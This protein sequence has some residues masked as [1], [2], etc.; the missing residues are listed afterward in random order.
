MTDLT[1]RAQTPTPLHARTAEL[2]ATNSWAAQ[3]SF[4]VPNVYSSEREE[5][6]ALASRVVLSDLSARQCWT[7]DGPDAGIYLSFATITDVTTLEPGQTTRTLWCDDQGNARGDGTIV[8]FGKDQFELTTSVRD[9]AWMLDGTL[10]F[11]VKVANATGT[12]A[13]ISVKGP[14][15]SSLL[16]V[17][18]FTGAPSNKGEV[19]Q[20][21]WRPAQIALMRDASGEGYELWTQAD[22]GVVVWDRLWRSG[23]G[24]GVSPMGAAAL[25]TQRIENASPIAGIDWWPAQ[26]SPDLSDCR[27]PVDLGFTPD[28]LRRFNGSDR[29]ARA[30]R[31]MRLVQVCAD[32]AMTVGGLTA[33]G[34]PAGTVTSQTWSDSRSRAFALAWI[35]EDAAKPGTQLM[36]SGPGGPVRAEI[37]RDAFSRFPGLV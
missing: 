16:S 15:A 14:L 32:E 24:L 26:L 27:S 8:R 30:V 7:F 9:F 36:T 22:D 19:V 13:V 2:C 20:P 25:E 21:T 35:K 37:I 28:P 5:L 4:T 12:R 29:V 31:T 23:A 18:G 10:G 6:E 1:T 11:D 34:A 3:H 17:A 33:R